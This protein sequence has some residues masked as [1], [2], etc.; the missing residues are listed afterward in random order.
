[1]I[2]QVQRNR[3][4]KYIA[5]TLFSCGQEGFEH[6]FEMRAEKSFHGLHYSVDDFTRQC[7]QCVHYSSVF[8]YRLLICVHSHAIKLFNALFMCSLVHH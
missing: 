6:E 8:T 4:Q 7:V 1:M 2:G 5:I 3:F